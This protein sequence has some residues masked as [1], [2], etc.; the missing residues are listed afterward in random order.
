M[1]HAAD[2]AFEAVVSEL[3]STSP[4]I[5]G[6]MV[7]MPCLTVAGKAFAGR[8]QEAMVFKLHGDA[9]AQALALRGAHLFDPSARDRPMRAWVEVPAEHAVVWPQLGRQALADVSRER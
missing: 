5:R 3:Q 9:H 2:A 1:A 4:A 8:Y 6:P 7:G